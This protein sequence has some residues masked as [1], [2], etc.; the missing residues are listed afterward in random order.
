[1]EIVEE[2]T[3]ENIVIESTPSKVS[4]GKEFRSAGPKRIVKKDHIISKIYENNEES[5]VWI[6]KNCETENPLSVTQCYVCQK[7]R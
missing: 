5:F 4:I 2:K 1:M 7:T 3:D 6:C